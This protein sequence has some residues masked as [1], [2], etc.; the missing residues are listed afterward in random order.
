MTT[1]CGSAHGQSRMSGAFPLPLDSLSIPSLRLIA[2]RLY[3][4][5]KYHLRRRGGCVSGSPCFLRSRQLLS[6]AKNASTQASAVCACSLCEVNS[7]LRCFS[8][9]QMPLCLTVRQKKTSVWV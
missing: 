8:L 3:S 4:I 6:E 9:S 2:D 5:R 7:R 1:V